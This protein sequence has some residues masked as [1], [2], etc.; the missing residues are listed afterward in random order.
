MVFAQFVCGIIVSTTVSSDILE[1]LYLQLWDILAYAS[2]SSQTLRLFQRLLL[3]TDF[4][5]SRSLKAI[6]EIV[7]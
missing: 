5:V 2:V 1:L 6:S 7:I 4:F 3:V